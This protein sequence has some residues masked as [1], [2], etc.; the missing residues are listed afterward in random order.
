M[1]QN[2]K[3]QGGKLSTNDERNPFFCLSLTISKG[4]TVPLFSI[5]IF[6]LTTLTKRTF[7]GCLGKQLVEEKKLKYGHG[8][9]EAHILLVLKVQ[10]R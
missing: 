1:A 7:S 8:L 3:S 2:S 9:K 10:L 6:I 5:G 4:F